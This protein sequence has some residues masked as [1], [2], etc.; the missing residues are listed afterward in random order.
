MVNAEKFCPTQDS[1]TCFSHRQPMLVVASVSSQR[2]FFIYISLKDF[3]YLFLE[4]GGEGERQGK[5][6]RCV[7]ASQVPSTG[8]LACNPGMCSDWELNQ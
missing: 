8:D 6:L 2:F 5:K 4:R 3:T 1:T 7:F